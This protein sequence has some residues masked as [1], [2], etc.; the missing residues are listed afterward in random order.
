MEKRSRSDSS[1]LADFLRDKQLTHSA[2]VTMRR[3]FGKTGVFCKGLMFGMVTNDML[4]LRIE[5]NNRAI[6]KEANSVPPLSYAKQGRTN[7]G[8]R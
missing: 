3:M 2:Q 6:F 1:L 8:T 5:D 4:Y 7:A